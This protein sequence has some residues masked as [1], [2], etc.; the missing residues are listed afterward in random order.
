MIFNKTDN[1]I[2]IKLAD[3]FHKFE[4]ECWVIKKKIFKIL[5]NISSHIAI[6]IKIYYRKKRPMC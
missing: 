4:N 3:N 2:M 5:K 6:Y 1:S